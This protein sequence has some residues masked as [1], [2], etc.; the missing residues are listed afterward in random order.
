ML[1]PE[2]HPKETGRDYA[3]R[4]IKQNIVTLD[5]APGS[6]VSENEL[7]VEMGLSRTPVREALIEL[8]KSG[9]VEIFPQKGSRVSKVRYSAVEE[10]RFMRLVLECAVVELACELVRE[11]DLAALEE[12]LKLQDFFDAHP[13]PERQLELD[14][15]FH[16]MIFRIA[17]KLQTYQLMASMSAHFDRV[18][19]MSLTSVKD[20]KITSDHYKLFAALRAH[21]GKTARA[22]MELHLSRY[23]VDEE[24]IRGQYPAYFD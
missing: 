11:E 8:S 16:R 10:A 4:V 7:A 24:A 5:L 21:D 15:E 9:I 18:R 12:N 2:R 17:C 13:V 14:N 23:K 6:M 22:A 19:S 1:L 20:M 3:L